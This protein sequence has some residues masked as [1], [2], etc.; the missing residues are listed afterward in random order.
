MGL[1]D[2]FS[3]MKKVSDFE[4]Y[5]VTPNGKI[6]SNKYGSLRELS[7]IPDK[8]G[9]LTVH[10]YK[11][12]KMY[13]KFVHQLVAKAF[14]EN[15]NN[16]TCVNHKDE[17]FNNNDVSNLEWCSHKYNSNYGSNIS[18]MR[19]SKTFRTIYQY[20]L[21]GKFIKEWFNAY[22]IQKVLGIHNTNIYRVCSGKKKTS[23]GYRWSF[24][25]VPSLEV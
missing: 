9:Y 18:R 16:Y 11:D 10:L 12:G 15:P 14:I 22:E 19:K 20:S 6:F 3:A 17:T 2:M 13:T 8:K 4:G 7:Q 25:K 21:D 5:F 24:I 1:K 23:H